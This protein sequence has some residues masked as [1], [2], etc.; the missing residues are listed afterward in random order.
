MGSTLRDGKQESRDDESESRDDDSDSFDL[1][2]SAA[3]VERDH[4]FTRRREFAL[5][6]RLVSAV[7]GHDPDGRASRNDEP[8]LLLVTKLRDSR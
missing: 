2:R 8:Q 3:I 5:Q 1:N 7:D 6:Q 4:D